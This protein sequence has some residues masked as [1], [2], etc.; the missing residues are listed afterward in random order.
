MVEGL[1]FGVE[2]LARKRWTR[3]GTPAWSQ[4]S[5]I[6]DFGSKSLLSSVVCLVFG[7]WESGFGVW[8][9][10]FGVWGLG[11]GLGVWWLVFGVWC[12]VFGVWCL[13]FGVWCLVFGVWCLMFGV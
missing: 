5:G 6:R 9:L 12:L 2:H 4:G 3:D 1:G 7:A 13:V 11:F 8:C 10:G